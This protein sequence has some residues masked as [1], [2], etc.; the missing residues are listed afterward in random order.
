MKLSKILMLAVLPL[1]LAACSVSTKFVSPVKPP[2]IAAP[3]SA[4]MKLCALPANIG[5]KP[6]TQEQVEDLWIADRVALLE[7]YR[8]HLALRNYIVD[9]D[10]AL[11]GGT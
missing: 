3:D 10:D 2:A 11:R 8:R 9:R 5:N 4:L 1:A 7:C 6:L